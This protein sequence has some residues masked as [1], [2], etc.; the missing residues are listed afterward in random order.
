MTRQINDR[1]ERRRIKK[2]WLNSVRSHDPHKIGENPHSLNSDHETSTKNQSSSPLPVGEV[3]DRLGRRH[4]WFLE[5]KPSPLSA[6]AST[7]AG[8]TN[9]D[10]DDGDDADEEEV[11]TQTDDIYGSTSDNVNT[12]LEIKKDKRRRKDNHITDNNN[13]EH[14]HPLWASTREENTYLP[15]DYHSR[16]RATSRNVRGTVVDEG[17]V[18]IPMYPRRRTRRN[19]VPAWEKSFYQKWPLQEAR[20]Q[21][22]RRRKRRRRREKWHVR[23]ETTTIKYM[24]WLAITCIVVVMIV[25]CTAAWCVC[26]RES[27]AR[28]SPLWQPLSYYPYYPPHQHPYIPYVAP[29]SH[30]M[31]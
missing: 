18:E 9:T 23:K 15:L 4:P 6:T 13:D 2:R 17:H 26:H 7:A 30:P 12:K 14:P 5:K 20:S 22:H 29:T 11:T 25:T 21:N 16:V 10:E 3:W 1:V 31:Q 24:M 28:T 19:A 27:P 8:T